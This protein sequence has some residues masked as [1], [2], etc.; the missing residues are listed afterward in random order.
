MIVVLV[1]IFQLVQMEVLT[2]A[3]LIWINRICPLK[4]QNNLIMV[5]VMVL[6]MIVTVL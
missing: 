1:L 6:M 3:M 5:P 2:L 4:K